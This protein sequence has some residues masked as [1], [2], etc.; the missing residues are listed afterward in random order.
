[1]LTFGY[2]HGENYSF[3]DQSK[4]I[5]SE[6]LTWGYPNFKKSGVIINARNKTVF[7]K[8]IIN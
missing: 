1:M 8:T 5:K 7:K 3:Y 6:A 2:C 4:D